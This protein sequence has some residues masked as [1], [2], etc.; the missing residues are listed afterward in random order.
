MLM[1]ERSG[2]ILEANPFI[3]NLL[4]YPPE[5]MKSLFLWELGDHARASAGRAAVEQLWQLRHLRS[6]D[7]PLLSKDGLRIHFEFRL[8]GAAQGDAGLV[9]CRFHELEVEAAYPHDSAMPA[10]RGHRRILPPLQFEEIADHEIE[11]TRDHGPPLSLL[12]VGV[13]RIARAEGIAAVPLAVRGF[14]KACSAPLR[15][16]DFVGKVD[17]TTFVVLL[18]GTTAKAA[19]SAAER[20]RTAIAATEI[21]TPDHQR[22]RITV[23]I[24]TVT[25]RTGRTSYAALRSRA[26][27]KRDDASSSGGNRVNG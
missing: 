15:S 5:A 27:A 9:E 17:S 8:L 22:R 13:D 18:P 3:S 4:L 11:R 1:L 20:L 14:A 19:R 24:G 6:S 26:D 2:R 16:T 25:T 12:S 7:L 23:S 10:H 21:P